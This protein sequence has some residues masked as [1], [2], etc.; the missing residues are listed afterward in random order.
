MRTMRG[1]RRPPAGGTRG[2]AG[3]QGGWAEI[4]VLAV[5]GAILGAAFL[6]ALVLH[7]KPVDDRRETAA[8]DTTASTLTAPTLPPPRRYPV[9]DGGVNIRQGPATNTAVLTRVE[10]GGRVRVICKTVGQDV[11][12]SSGSTNLWLRVDLGQFGLGY[13]S[14]LYVDTGDDIED[15]TRIGDCALA[16]VG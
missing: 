15:F 9:T 2:E 7:Q 16:P 6:W 8:F 4:V 3:G 1:G 5:F 12:G 11:S 13:A 10:D 14:A